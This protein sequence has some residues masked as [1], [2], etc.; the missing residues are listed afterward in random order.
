MR[1]VHPIVATRPSGEQNPRMTP[2]S[3][4]RIGPDTVSVAGEIDGS[5]AA[6]LGEACAELGRH[7]SIECSRCEFIDSAGVSALL[8]V[9]SRVVPEGG[10]VTLVNPSP[11]VQR[12]VE[13]TGLEDAF[14]I[15]DHRN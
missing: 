7:V 2:F 8:A 9:R 12:M 15:V 11:A 3:V 13:I 14:R 5:T 6:V 1:S 10:D 4:Q